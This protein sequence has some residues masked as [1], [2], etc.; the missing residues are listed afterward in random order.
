[1][2]IGRD[3]WQGFAPRR[4]F[5][6]CSIA[7]AAMSVIGC[8]ISSAWLALLG[9]WLQILAA[10][11]SVT[12]R[13]RS[14]YPVALAMP[15]LFLAGLPDRIADRPGTALTVRTMQQILSNSAANNRLVWTPSISPTFSSARLV[16][17]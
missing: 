3:A 17:H 1:M 13:P 12:V 8:L 16:C 10:A 9:L 7:A 11:M 2:L 15:W 4:A 5:L 6:L 14:L